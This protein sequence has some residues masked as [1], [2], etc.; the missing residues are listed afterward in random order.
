MTGIPDQKV[1]FPQPVEHGLQLGVIEIGK[2][3]SKFLGAPQRLLSTMADFTKNQKTDEYFVVRAAK[4]G[5]EGAEGITCPQEGEEGG[6]VGRLYTGA[7]KI[8]GY[9]GKMT[10]LELL[11]R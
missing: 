5:R 8:I 4:E 7:E 9:H 2:M 6:K 3:R 10:S 11:Q 1:G